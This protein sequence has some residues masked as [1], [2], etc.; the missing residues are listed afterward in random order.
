MCL[1]QWPAW[2]CKKGRALTL[3]WQQWGFSMRHE[4]PKLP[5]QWWRIALMLTFSP[6][7]GIRG[8]YIY[9]QSPW[10]GVNL[11]H[12]IFHDRTPA[13]GAPFSWDHKHMWQCEYHIR[14]WAKHLQNS[15]NKNSR[16]WTQQKS[17]AKKHK[18]PFYVFRLNRF[19]FVALA[20]SRQIWRHGP[21]WPGAEVDK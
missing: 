20:K 1:R 19:L 12:S 4:L 15:T 16:N 9:S 3:R 2:W 8:L 21:S 7:C 5:N 14:T 6:C 13:A 11:E 18:H 17:V 10:F